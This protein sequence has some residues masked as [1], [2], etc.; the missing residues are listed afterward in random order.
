MSDS[1]CPF[2]KSEKRMVET[3]NSELKRNG[4]YGPIMRPCCKAT[5]RN[6]K[7]IEEN[8]DPR[9]GPKK[10]LEDIEKW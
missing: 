3:T 10:E 9:L 6:L 7:Y 8:Y 5:A 1:P 2:C 4:E